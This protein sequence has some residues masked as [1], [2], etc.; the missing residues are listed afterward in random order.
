[1]KKFILLLFCA[2]FTNSIIAQVRVSEPEFAE[3][4]A[5]LTSDTTSVILERENG[6]LKTKAGASLYLVGIGKIKSR[7]TID[8]AK[9]ISKVLGSKNTR[10]IIKAEDNKTDPK[11]FID[12]FKFDVYKNKER[13]YQIAEAGT[14]SA[15][16]SNNLSSIDYVAKKYGETSYLILLADLTPGEYGIILG[17]PNKENTKNNMKIT[18]FTVE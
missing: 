9:S 6:Y 13:R 5:L 15:V 3:Q 18:T 16:K 17:D 10:L 8:G 7:I 11:S 12:I 2:I 14:L 4:I 1:M